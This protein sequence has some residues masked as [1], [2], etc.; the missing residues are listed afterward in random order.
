[1]PRIH[2]QGFVDGLQLCGHRLAGPACLGDHPCMTEL[3]ARAFWVSIHL[4]IGSHPKTLGRVAPG[5][6]DVEARG[7]RLP[8]LGGRLAHGDLPQKAVVRVHHPPPRDGGRVHVQP[9]KPAQR[10]PRRCGACRIRFWKSAIYSES[11][12]ENVFPN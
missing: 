8:L 3:N 11:R 5:D 7:A 10:P 1:M 4:D 12:G 6:R 2:L 9:H